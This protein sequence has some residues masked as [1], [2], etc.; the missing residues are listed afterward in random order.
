[1]SGW[2]KVPAIITAS[3]AG[4]IIAAFLALFI[5]TRT[6]WFHNYVEQK[7]VTSLQDATGGRVE[8]GSYTIDW[9]HFRVVMHDLIIHGREPANAAPLLRAPLVQADVS[10]A[11]AIGGGSV[12]SALLVNSPS[13][14]VIV[15]P[16]GSTNIPSPKVKKSDKN[17]FQTIADLSI[18][19]LE[20]SNGTLLFGD[21]KIPLD[22]RGENVHA[23]L[24]SNGGTSHGEVSITPL[25]VRYGNNAP[26]DIDVKVP[27][28]L[29]HDSIQVNGAR[30]ATPQSLITLSGVIDHLAQPR[31]KAHLSGHVALAE[32]KRAAGSAVELRTSGNAPR[33]L[34]VDSTVT[35]AGNRIDVESARLSLGNSD[36]RAS[37]VLKDQGKPA[38]LHFDATLALGQLGALLGVVVAARE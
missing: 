2:R 7:I 3:I 17:A 35:V 31:A 19:H 24:R 1:M 9:D 8:I 10:L 27:V 26:V 32:V 12:L 34:N 13:A 15:Y 18:G 20:L 14:N 4:L 23:V 37:G 22:A 33:I 16:D 36:I 30:V 21:L 38:G 25:H 5:V 6:A 29:A 11:S 28:V